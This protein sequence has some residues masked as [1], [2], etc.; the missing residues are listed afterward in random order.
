MQPRTLLWWLDEKDNID[1]EPVNQ[2]KGE[3][4]SP[5]DKSFLIDSIF[6][7]YNIPKFYLADFTYVSTGLNHKGKKFAVIDG[8]QRFESIKNFYDGKLLL[9]PDFGDQ[10]SSTEVRGPWV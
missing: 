1:F 4:W 6:T 9:N 7:E 2:R 3:V 8:K 5:E 10:R